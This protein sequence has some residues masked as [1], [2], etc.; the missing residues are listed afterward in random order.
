MMRGALAVLVALVASCA[1][2][3]RTL[4]ATHPATATA[5]AGRL[6]GAPAALRP[7]VVDYRDVPKLREVAPPAGHQHHHHP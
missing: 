5:P 7:G 6:A 2:A 1:V 4:P 3:P